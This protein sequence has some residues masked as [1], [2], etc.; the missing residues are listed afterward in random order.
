M[1]NS[2]VEIETVVED[3][4][5][6]GVSN[7]KCPSRRE[8]RRR[9]RELARQSNSAKK[10]IGTGDSKGSTTYS[11][12]S[13]N[14]STKQTYY[15]P[16][17]KFGHSCKSIP[18]G[19]DDD[20]ILAQFDTP[21]I[22]DAHS[23]I[24][25]AFLNHLEKLLTLRAPSVCSALKDEIVQ[26]KYWEK[27]LVYGY[28]WKSLSTR[29]YAPPHTDLA[30]NVWSIPE[31]ATRG[32]VAHT[33][34]VSNDTGPD[35][36]PVIHVDG[37]IYSLHEKRPIGGDDK[38]GVAIALAVAEFYPQF[39]CILVA[40]EEIG[41]VGSSFMSR[42]L[43]IHDLL[44]QND[45][46]GANDLVGEIWGSSI[47]SKSAID[48]ALELLPH[49][50]SEQGMMTDVQEF[51]DARRVKN[52]F[53]MSCGYYGPHS[54]Q[55]HVVVMEAIQALNDTV[56]L[57]TE[58]PHVDE[59]DD[60]LGKSYTRGGPFT[61]SVWE[62]EYYGGYDPYDKGTVFN[63][64]GGKTYSI[65]TDCDDSTLREYSDEYTSGG[66]HVVCGDILGEQVIIVSTDDVEA[67]FGDPVAEAIEHCVAEALCI[68]PSSVRCYDNGY[69][70]LS[71]YIN[72]SLAWRDDMSHSGDTHKFTVSEED[73]QAVFNLTKMRDIHDFTVNIKRMLDQ[74]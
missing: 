14:N 40:N 72:V 19:L 13:R 56:K 34:V 55:E 53:N 61:G 48:A 43:P 41:C 31:N 17:E 58:M 32:V 28:V 6:R 18:A 24:E 36:E 42:D 47:A 49:R 66:N 10:Y 39:S 8:R 16:E 20:S 22:T 27:N 37:I 51:A 5:T 21:V 59:S 26:E 73:V 33:D 64:V 63:G 57:L 9:N 35:V 2:I 62:K 50:K 70:G 1:T 44:V 74:D 45:R 11:Y 25:V 68:D 54:A 29:L 52:A 38:V 67:K 12:W 60:F 15:F 46:R 69:G 7:T 4:T 23:P 30:G 65:E 3:D 71:G